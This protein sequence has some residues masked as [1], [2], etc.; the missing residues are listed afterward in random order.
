MQSGGTPRGWKTSILRQQEL[1]RWTPQGPSSGLAVLVMGRAWLCA[2][3]RLSKR[4]TGSCQIKPPFVV[5]NLNQAGA[6]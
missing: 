4:G 2:A 3:Q 5:L 1:F 6:G